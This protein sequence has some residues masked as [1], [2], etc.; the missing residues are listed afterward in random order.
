MPSLPRRSTVTHL[1]RWLQLLPPPQGTY[2]SPVATMTTVPEPSLVPR[3][4][5]TVSEVLP[6]FPAL[7]MALAS[8]PAA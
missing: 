4:P 3:I 2:R 5:G 7:S 8:A 1:G 6:L